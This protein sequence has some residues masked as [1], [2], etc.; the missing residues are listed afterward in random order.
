MRLA[1]IR[2][3]GSTSAGRVIG[4][5]IA[6]LPYT[7]VGALLAAGPDWA[8]R[9][10]EP[11]AD[12]VSVS[13][14]DF[15]PVVPHPE[16]IICAGINYR[17]HIAE[18]GLKE[19]DIPRHP[20][21]FAKFARSLIG[22]NDDIVLP[23]NSDAVDFE[24]EL[25]VVIGGAVRNAS[26]QEAWAAI[27]GYT[28]VN[29]ISMRDWQVRTSQFLQGK[30][31]EASTPVGPYLVTPDEVG[32]ARRLG[33]C[34]ALDDQVMQKSNT[35]ELLFS[36]VQLVSYISSFITLVPGDLIATGTPGGTGAARRP[37]VFLAAGQ[38]VSCMIDGLGEQVNQCVAR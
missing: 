8:E 9:A 29:D 30:T 28:I 7:D 10:Q 13:E 22:A 4:D 6:L 31:F 5:S 3:N 37:P 27:A 15:A 17:D 26:E 12:L 1:T 14:A 32:H 2:V 24:V 36:A 25:G 33:V 16:K 11:T 21:L 19:E 20:T 18:V 23:A 38:T 34:C 35:K